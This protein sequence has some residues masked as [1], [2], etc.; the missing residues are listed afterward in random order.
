MMNELRKYKLKRL[1]GP[2]ARVHCVLHVLNL[3]AKVR[4]NILSMVQFELQLI[5]INLRPLHSR[6]AQS[7]NSC[8]MRKRRAQA[9]GS[10]DV[11]EDDDDD[12]DNAAPCLIQDV[13]DR[14]KL[15]EAVLTFFSRTTTM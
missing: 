14:G 12:E 3:V 2:E 13:S 10:S 7:A 4:I 6:S 1:V 15:V 5:I 11:D 8:L 9:Q